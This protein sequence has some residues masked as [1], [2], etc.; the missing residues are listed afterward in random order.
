MFHLK[1]LKLIH[2]FYFRIILYDAIKLLFGLIKYGQLPKLISE[3]TIYII[4]KNRIR[5]Y[6]IIEMSLHLLFP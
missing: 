2:Y 6:M 3:K 5:V 4:A 1:Y